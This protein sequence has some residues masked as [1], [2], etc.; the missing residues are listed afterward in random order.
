MAPVELL[1]LDVVLAMNVVVCCGSSFSSAVEE[2]IVA[3]F[4]EGGIS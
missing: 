3:V 1:A 2:I 4:N